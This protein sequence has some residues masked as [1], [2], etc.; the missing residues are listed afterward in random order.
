MV[1]SGRIMSNKRKNLSVDGK[2]EID[3]LGRW[4]LSMSFDE[5]RLLRH[6]R[7]FRDFVEAAQSLRRAHHSIRTWRPAPR[8]VEV[9]ED[10]GGK[11]AELLNF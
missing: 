5:I 7:E 1:V 8:R 2:R 3:Q 6:T 4:L 11:E 9:A 10:Q